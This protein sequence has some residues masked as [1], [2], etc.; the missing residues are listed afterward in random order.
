VTSE[1]RNENCDNMEPV[2]TRPGRE[3]AEHCKAGEGQV[4]DPPNPI[5]I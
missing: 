2:F 4:A 1:G 5:L 3:H